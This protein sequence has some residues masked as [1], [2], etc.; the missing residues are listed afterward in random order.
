MRMTLLAPDIVEAIL[1]GRELSE[2]SLT[3]LMLPFPAGWAQQNS[4]FSTAQSG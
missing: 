3:T 2:I 4:I 1:E